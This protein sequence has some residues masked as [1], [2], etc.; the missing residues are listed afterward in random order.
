MGTCRATRVRRGDPPIARRTFVRRLVVALG[1]MPSAAS[2]QRAARPA[3][4]GFLTTGDPSPG[5]MRNVVE[6]M[7]LG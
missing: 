1:A 3:M 7:R 4:L 5:A 2:A 6:P